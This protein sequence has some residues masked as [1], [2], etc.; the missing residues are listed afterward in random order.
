MASLADR[1][2]IPVLYL[3]TARRDYLDQA[4]ASAEGQGRVTVEPG[5]VGHTGRARAAAFAKGKAEFVGLL[6]YDDLLLPGAVAACLEALERHP[7]AVGAYTG[8]RTID[9]QGA[10]T[11]TVEA[12]NWSPVHMLCKLGSPHT[13]IHFTLMRRAAMMRCLDVLRW[14]EA[15]VLDDTCAYSALTQFGPWVHIPAPLYRYR[16]HPGNTTNGLT[17]EYCKAV[18]RRITPL[19]MPVIK[20]SRAWG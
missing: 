11:A 7:E 4:I 9:A 10:I 19:L 14:P 6:D 16:R 18:I 20:R 1:V 17:P 2:D 13:P 3:P 8:Y 12:R 5:I 15:A